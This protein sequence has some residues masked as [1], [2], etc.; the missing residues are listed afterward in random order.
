M[1]DSYCG[2]ASLLASPSLSVKSGWTTHT[3]IW[4]TA[5][6]SCIRTW[7][8]WGELRWWC[9]FLIISLKMMY[10]KTQWN[11]YISKEIW[12]RFLTRSFFS[13][14]VLQSDLPHPTIRPDLFSLLNKLVLPAA[15]NIFVRIRISAYNRR[16][17]QNTSTSRS[18]RRGND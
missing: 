16:E 12:H 9:F 4:F 5:P 14:L 10:S 7:K 18:I 8:S 6:S 3:V 2:W 11:G 15:V 17:R 1:T 13:S